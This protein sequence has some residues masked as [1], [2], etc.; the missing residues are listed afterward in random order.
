MKRK[1]AAARKAI[2]KK[3]RDTEAKYKAQGRKER[4]DYSFERGR[5]RRKTARKRM[6]KAESD[7]LAEHAIPDDLLAIWHEDRGRYSY[8]LGPDMRAEQF[9]EWAEAH[10]DEIRERLQSMLEEQWTDEAFAE[11]FEAYRRAS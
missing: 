4:E 9:L 6:S 8:E 1:C 5:Q 7:S 10:E 2:R 3:A 11:D